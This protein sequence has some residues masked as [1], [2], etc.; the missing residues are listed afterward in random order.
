[1]AAEDASRGHTFTVPE[2]AYRE[3]LYMVELHKQHGAPNRFETVEDMLD[4]ILLSV[5]DGSRRPGAW[6]RGMLEQMG[7]IAECPEHH[8]HRDSYGKPSQPSQD[9]GAQRA[10]NG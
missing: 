9:K 4:F 6:E 1:M 7:L 10:E 5:A 3:L 8:V 2:G